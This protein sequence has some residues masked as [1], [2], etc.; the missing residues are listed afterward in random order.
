MD[1]RKQAVKVVAGLS[2]LSGEVVFDAAE[3]RE[4]R[5]LLVG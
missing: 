2:D 1:L 3:H 4:R 5:E